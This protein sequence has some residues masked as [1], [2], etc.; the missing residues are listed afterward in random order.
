[1]PESSIK[2]E[3]KIVIVVI[4]YNG[5]EDTRECLKSLNNVKYNN[6]N[7]I[8]VDNASR[9][10]PIPRLQKDFPE[11]YYI[12]TGKNLGFTGGNNIG[13]EKARE[14]KPK[15]V[16]FLNNDTVVSENILSELSIFMD[17]NLDVGIV[18]PLTYY[19][20]SKV[21]ISFGGAHLNRNT[22]SIIF[23]NKGKTPRRLSGEVIYCSFIE[24]AALFLR[25][26]LATRIGGFNNEYFLTSEESELC[27]KIADMSY[28]LAVVTRC[29]VWHKVSQSMGSGSELTN[30]FV[31]RNKLLFIKRNA[32]GFRLPHLI[33]IITHYGICLIS[34]A[35]K[36]RNPCAVK[37]LITGTYDFIAGIT[38]PGRYKGRLNA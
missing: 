17:A 6:F 15:Y 37:G 38:G 24:G 31:F 29:S 12:R 5:F 35:V 28:K 22:G 19:Y 13:L 23:L 26:D 8:V 18:G 30:Y 27:I 16:F 32:L 11:V 14:L 10:N 21:V 20:D 4:N 2:N 9:D 3:S 1:M 7:V 25:M 34:F 33:H 36:K